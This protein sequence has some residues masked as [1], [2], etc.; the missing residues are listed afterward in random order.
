MIFPKYFLITFIKLLLSGV[1]LFAINGCQVDSREQALK[2]TASQV[3]LRAMQTRAFDTKDQITML[4]TAIATLQD[5]GFIIDKADASIGTCSAT[6]Y[7][8]H[9]FG[10]PYALKMTITVRPRGKNQ[11]LV[12]ANAQYNLQAIEEPTPY[13]DFFVAFEKAIFLKAHNV[14]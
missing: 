8:K 6:K 13:R 3:K 9:N 7:G 14:D 2:T 1:I 10:R 11:S 12:R 5:L 4:R